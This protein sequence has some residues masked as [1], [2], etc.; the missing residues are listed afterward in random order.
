MDLIYTEIFTPRW[1]TVSLRIE[2]EGACYLLERRGDEAYHNPQAE[3][4]TT[5]ADKAT[6]TPGEQDKN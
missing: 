5:K 4:V 1:W 3:T 6:R 2:S